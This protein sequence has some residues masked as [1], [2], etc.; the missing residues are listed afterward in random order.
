MGTIVG[1]F[2]LVSPAVVTIHPRAS[3]KTYTRTLS[4]RGSLSGHA[5]RWNDHVAAGDKVGYRVGGRVLGR[6]GGCGTVDR[7]SGEKRTGET[8]YVFGITAINAVSPVCFALDPP[9]L[10][11]TSIATLFRNQP[12]VDFIHCPVPRL[13]PRQGVASL[14]WV[15]SDVFLFHDARGKVVRRR[16][17]Q[18]LF[19]LRV[20]AERFD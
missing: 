2:S 12:S 3:T 13:L 19:N 20:L 4:L 10:V 16:S 1:V 14:V 15:Y 17:P 5:D 7:E 18:V 9:T 8:T 11:Q 6:R